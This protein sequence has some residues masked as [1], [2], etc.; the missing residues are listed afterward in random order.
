MACRIANARLLDVERLPPPK[1][2]PLFALLL[3]QAGVDYQQAAVALESSRETIRMI[4]LPFEDPRRRVPNRKL[5]VRI[6]DWCGGRVRPAD[7]Y[8]P[9]PQV[10]EEAAA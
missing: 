1:P 7:F 10:L 3:F 2:M 5:M 9:V 6:V 4:C 8:E